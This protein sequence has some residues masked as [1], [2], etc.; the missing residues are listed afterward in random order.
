MTEYRLD[1]GSGAAAQTIA[2]TTAGGIPEVIWWGATLPGNEDLSQLAAAARHDLTG[3]ML[4]ALPHLSL[5]PE[6]GRAFQGQPGLMMAALDGAPLL[7]RFAFERAEEKAGVLRLVSVAEGLRLTHE[8]RAYPTGVIGLRAT[9]ESKQPVRV[10]WLAAPVL[11]AP[12]DGDILDVHGKWTREF[13]LN[14]VAWTPG[15]R[16]REARTGRSGH[17]HPPYVIFAGQGTT[18]TKGEARA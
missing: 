2:L 1:A 15:A 17:E 8:L 3:G 6:A 16:L 13:H 14:R 12:Q 7:P 9:L 10:H 11:P 18:K 5:C 4:D